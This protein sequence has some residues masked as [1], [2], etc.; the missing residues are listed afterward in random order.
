[1]IKIGKPVY[2][3]GPLRAG[4]KNVNTNFKKEVLRIVTAKSRDPQ[5]DQAACMGPVQRNRDEYIYIYKL[6]NF[7]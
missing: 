5:T 6:H 3:G 4:R 2:A 1:M 7:L